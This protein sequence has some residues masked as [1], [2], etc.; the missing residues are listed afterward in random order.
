MSTNK[1]NM[2]QLSHN[3]T[4]EQLQKEQN[5]LISWNT[6]ITILLGS[7][8]ILTQIIDTIISLLIK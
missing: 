4:D 6:K 1:E 7:F 5:D 2:S 3:K 8:A